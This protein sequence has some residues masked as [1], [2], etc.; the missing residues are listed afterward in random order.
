MTSKSDLKKRIRARQAK[1]GETYSTARAHVLAARAASAQNAQD[2]ES[3]QEHLTAIVLK[4][5]KTSLRVQVLGEK[6][7][8]TL[9]CSSYEAWKVV[10]AQFVE[11]T[12]TKR[13]TWHDGA[14][15]SGAVERAWTD[16]PAL[17]LDPIELDDRGV[18]DLNQAYT[19]I[20]PPDPSWQIWAAIAA[21]P[22]KVFEFGDIAWGE[23][24]DGDPEECL[25]RQ[26]SQIIDHHPSE[27]RRLLMEA[28]LEAPSC[29]DAHVHLGY[30]AFDANPQQAL[31]H[32]EIAAQIGELSLGADFDGLLLWG[33][34]NNRPFLR[35]LKGLALCLWR[36]GDFDQARV[37][38]EQ[39]LAF[40][41]PDNQ[42]NRFNLRDVIEGLPWGSE[43]ETC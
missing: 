13:W 39:I 23:N 28:V 24:V 20:L 14:Y 8:L 19:P 3:G 17:G 25:T 10:P 22:R 16:V 35:A 43:L 36:K 15:A 37:I 33:H 40:N 42:G 11:V 29:I 41:P 38:F 32:Y 27:A 21:A 4:C 1:T 6:G 18:V 12:V 7:T 26:A 30:L 2:Q 5:N 34:M 31:T 9:R